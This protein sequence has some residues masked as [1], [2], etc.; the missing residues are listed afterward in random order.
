MFSS[1]RFC[2]P[3]TRNWGLSLEKNITWLEVPCVLYKKIDAYLQE[4]G[5]H[6]G[7]ECML[8]TR[9][10]LPSRRQKVFDSHLLC[11][12]PSCW[13]ESYEENCMSHRL[14]EEKIWNVYPRTSSKLPSIWFHLPTLWN[15]HAPKWIYATK[16]M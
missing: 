9:S 5:L 14:I 10:I 15:F 3:W 13:R 7:D 11:W 16:I 8:I 4:Q 1:S 12:W 6:Y 2:N